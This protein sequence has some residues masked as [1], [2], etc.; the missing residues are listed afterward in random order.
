MLDS[1][2]YK[3]SEIWRQPR[4]ISKKIALAAPLLIIRNWRI[5]RRGGCNLKSFQDF[6]SEVNLAPQEI[7]KIAPRCSKFSPNLAD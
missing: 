6:V 4:K 1:L 3:I 2:P 7:L 5:N